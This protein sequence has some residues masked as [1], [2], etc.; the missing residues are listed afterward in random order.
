MSNDDLKAAQE[1]M[2]ADIAAAG[3]RCRNDDDGCA[4]VEARCETFAANTG[5][6][7]LRDKALA[8]A[9]AI[10]AAQFDAAIDAIIAVLGEMDDPLARLDDARR[11][12]VNGKDEL[13]IP[14][15]AM[16]T[17]QM[18]A[19]LQAVQ[20]AIENIDG[21]LASAASGGGVTEALRETIT[22]LR[23]LRERLG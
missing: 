2:L 15:L 18:L 5:Y 17:S 12:A 21:S 8:I 11:A 20:R 6:D 9:D 16:V 4:E 19:R 3:V 1:A 14:R 13:L 23:R 7:D 22:S 10:N